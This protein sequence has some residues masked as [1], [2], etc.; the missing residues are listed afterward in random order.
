MNLKDYKWGIV[1]SLPKPEYWEPR[2]ELPNPDAIGLWV[3][4]Q[5]FPKGMSRPNPDGSNNSV[6]CFKTRDDARKAAAT[7]NNAGWTYA[8]KKFP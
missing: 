1:V 7:M 3:L 4:S 8:V 6:A 2:G 5:V